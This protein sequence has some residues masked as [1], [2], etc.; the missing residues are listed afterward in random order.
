MSLVSTHPPH[1]HTDVFLA[2]PVPINGSL[3]AFNLVASDQVVCMGSG[4]IAII[5]RTGQLVPFVTFPMSS[6]R[7][8][9]W[10]GC[11]VE[12]VVQLVPGDLNRIE[13]LA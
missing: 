1:S 2:M 9:I 12:G 4:V 13:R 6:V 10:R 11:R 8:Q 7:R 5:R 3:R